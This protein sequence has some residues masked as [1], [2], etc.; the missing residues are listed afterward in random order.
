MHI[1]SSKEKQRIC[2]AASHG[3]CNVLLL[4]CRAGTSCSLA[5]AAR[6]REMAIGHRSCDSHK[7]GPVPSGRRSAA[8][9][10]A[11]LCLQVG[12]ARPCRRRRRQDGHA[13][14]SREHHHDSKRRAGTDWNLAPICQIERL[15]LARALPRDSLGL[16]PSKLQSFRS[17]ERFRLFWISPGAIDHFAVHIVV[18]LYFSISFSS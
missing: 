14:V 17:N 12:S 8:L 16:A 7:P 1:I 6:A 4:M 11:D 10:A 3:T 9:W 13:T 5:I 18:E 15:S 2:V